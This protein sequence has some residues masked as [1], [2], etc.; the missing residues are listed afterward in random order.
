MKVSKSKASDN[1]D[2]I[3]Q[4]ASAQMR[5][6]GLEQT[7]IADVAR[8]SG[9]THGA[10]YSHFGSK[11]TLATEALK[12]AFADCLREFAGLSAPQ[13]LK[14]YLSTEHRDHPEMGCPAAALV[15]EIARQPAEL[16]TVFRGGVDRFV[17]LAGESLEAAAAEHGRDRAV[18]MF[19]AMMGGLSLSRAI[20]DVDA[21]GSADIL[22]AVKKQLGLLLL[23]GD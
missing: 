6:R 9:L 8:A 16:Q 12:C 1:R 19:A 23:T 10:L 11:D 3:L 2:A 18:L 14:R 22:R 17:A 15:S 20:R 5:G 4:A 7:S 13:F 21:S